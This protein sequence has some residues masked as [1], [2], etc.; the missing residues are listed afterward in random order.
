MAFFMPA[1]TPV[2]II[3]RM[4]KE[5]NGVLAMPDVK[6]ELVAQ[7]MDLDPGTSTEL[8]ARIQA[9]VQKWREVIKRTGISPQ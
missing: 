8:A 4:N 9:D 5:I 6:K 7:G 2:L 3:E 1:R